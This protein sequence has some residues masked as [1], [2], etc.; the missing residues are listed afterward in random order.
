MLTFNP[1]LSYCIPLSFLLLSPGILPLLGR[2]SADSVSLTSQLILFASR[3]EMGRSRGAVW[4][5][6]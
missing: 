1:W 5:I 2:E 4:I 3:V 6:G